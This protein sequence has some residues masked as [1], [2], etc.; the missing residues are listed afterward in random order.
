MDLFATEGYR[1][2]SM[3]RIAAEVGL[4]HAGV[5]HHFGTKEVLLEAVIEHRDKLDYPLRDALTGKHGASVFE[6]IMLVGEHNTARP[7][8]AQLYTVLLAGSLQDDAAG[9][10][11][12]KARYRF[13]RKGIA[14]SIRAGQAKGEIRGDVDAAAVANRILA[15]LDGLQTSWLL[16][17]EEVSLVEGMREFSE[18]L[19]RDLAPS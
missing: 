7:G 2:T 16:D 8:L 18:S 10:Q 17:P 12:F 19:R 5:L 4:T 6:G 11:Y 15:T 13:M 1:A 9:H 3:G 14:A